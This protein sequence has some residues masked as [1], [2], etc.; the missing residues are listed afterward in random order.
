MTFRSLRRFVTR[1]LGIEALRTDNAAQAA[2]L[3]A[4]QDALQ[5]QQ[6]ELAA[7]QTVLEAHQAGLDQYVADINAIRGQLDQ[8]LLQVAELRDETRQQASTAQL[9]QSI[10]WGTMWNAAD[11]TQLPTLVSVVLPTRNRADLLPRAVQSVLQ[12]ANVR[13]ELI[14]VDDASTDHT[15]KMLAAIKDPRLTVLAGSGV[16]AAAARNLA[17]T[18]ATGE[19]IAFADDDNIMAPGW[20][21][22]VARHLLQNESSAGVYGAQIREP[23]QGGDIT[24]LYRAPFS[25]E[26]M[27]LGPFIDL[28]ATAFRA[29]IDELHFDES[30]TALLDWDMLIRITAK[31]SLDAIPVLASCY[32]TSAPDRISTRPDKGVALRTVQARAAANR[33]LS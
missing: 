9:A 5:A 20:L 12:Q 18:H 23:E 15:S 24:L 17:I 26:H 2:S 3:A 16:G 8:A 28:G 33:K 27:L 14:V 7:H 13:V 29:N 21:A 32:T 30:L 31:Q 4:H 6:A 1:R 11:L 19:I 25:H 22:A 10:I